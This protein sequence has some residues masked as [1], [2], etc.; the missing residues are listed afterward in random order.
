LEYCAEVAADGS[1]LDFRASG[2]LLVPD[3]DIPGDVEG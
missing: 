1:P 3:A 2:V